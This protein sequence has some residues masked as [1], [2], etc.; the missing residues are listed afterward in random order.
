MSF[1]KELKIDDQNTTIEDDS[2]DE[3]EEIEVIDLTLE[4][5]LIKNNN[6]SVNNTNTVESKSDENKDFQD[7]TVVL[8]EFSDGSYVKAHTHKIDSAD[9]KTAIENL[10]TSMESDNQTDN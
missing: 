8:K 1:K 2:N 10:N 7:R 6:I 3:N 9:E 4:D 5:N